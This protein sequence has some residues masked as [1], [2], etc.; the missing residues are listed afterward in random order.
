[1]AL[2]R[3]CPLSLAQPSPNVNAN[4]RAVITFIN[5]G[6]VIEKNGAS[7]ASFAITEVPS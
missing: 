3:V 7:E 4:T 1:M 5:G 6:I 2:R